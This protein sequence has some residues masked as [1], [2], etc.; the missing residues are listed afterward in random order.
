MDASALE[1]VYTCRFHW[2]WI[3]EAALDPRASR[4]VSNARHL[5]SAAGNDGGD[6]S[7]KAIAKSP[8]PQIVRRHHRAPAPLRVESPDGCAGGWFSSGAFHRLGDKAN[9]VE[10]IAEVNAQWCQPASLVLPWDL[11]LADGAADGE[12]PSFKAAEARVA[13]EFPGGVPSCFV[14]KPSAACGGSGILF[15]RDVA[16]AVEAVHKDAQRARQEPGF[17][18]YLKTAFGGVPRWCLQAHIT[19]ALIHKGRKF[20]VRSYLV[21]DAPGEGSRGENGGGGG[22]SGSSSGGGGGCLLMYQDNHEVRVANMPYDGLP[23]ADAQLSAHLT[24]GAGGTKT[25]R[26]LFREVPELQAHLETLETFIGRLFG[27]G[28]LGRIVAE[29]AHQDIVHARALKEDRRPRPAHMRR[30]A[31]CALDLM[32]DAEG[33][34]YLLEVNA[35]APGAPPEIAVPDDSLFRTHLCT[36]SR[37][38]VSLALGKRNPCWLPL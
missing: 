11:T 30:L 27:P 21:Y 25:H 29:T 1:C 18:D 6:N 35:T 14:L 22:G 9:L 36:L 3:F 33:R 38:L 5:P 26:C 34:W 8:R 13:E 24:N 10:A 19:S 20:H 4:R 37:E 31:I 15:F 28:A 23:G 2:Q 17:I 32:L 16:S 7:Q 12:A